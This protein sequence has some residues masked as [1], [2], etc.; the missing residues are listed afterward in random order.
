MNIHNLC[1]RAS[2]ALACLRICADK[3]GHSLLADAI[4]T[5]ILYIG[6]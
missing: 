5:K 4:N 3:P 6:P 2:K 1:I